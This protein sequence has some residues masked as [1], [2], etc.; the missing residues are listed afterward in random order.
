MSLS[1]TIAAVE[2]VIIDARAS[3]PEAQGSGNWADRLAVEGSKFSWSSSIVVSQADA[4]APGCLDALL[5][6]RSQNAPSI[7]GSA[8]SCVFVVNM[9]DFERAL[10]SNALL[11][12]DVTSNRGL[13]DGAD[14]RAEIG[15]V[16]KCR[17]ARTKMRKFHSQHPRRVRF[18]LSDELCR[19]PPRIRLNKQMHV[20]W[21]HFERV[22]FHV[23]QC[24]RLNDQFDKA[25]LDAARQHRAPVLRA[26]DNVVLEA[27]NSSGILD[28]ACAPGIH[29][30]LYNCGAHNTQ[31]DGG[32]RTVWASEAIAVRAIIVGA[33]HGQTR[34]LCEIARACAVSRRPNVGFLLRTKFEKR[35]CCRGG[36][37]VRRS[38]KRVALRPPQRCPTHLEDV[39]QIGRAALCTARPSAQ[40]PMVQARR[41][42]R[43]RSICRPR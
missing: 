24:R 40:R 11:C 3:Q 37:P 7:S 36:L 21:Q 13:R 23:A 28:V 31:E 27:E 22:N 19:R 8:T 30:G 1:S 10:H 17:Q 4:A 18:D 25:C 15:S 41:G 5:R 20:I 42:R 29:V 6:E 26:P 35:C 38:K 14:R 16:P 12:F 32:C 39:N 33:K 2:R 9:R 34:A 43:T